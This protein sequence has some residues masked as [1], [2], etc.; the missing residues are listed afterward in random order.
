VLALSLES[1]SDAER[2][3]LVM[4][5]AKKKTATANPARQKTKW[6]MLG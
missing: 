6:P 5:A 1:M 2:S 3:D 4:E